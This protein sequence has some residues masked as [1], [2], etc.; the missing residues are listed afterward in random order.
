MVVANT[1]TCSWKW[2]DSNANAPSHRYGYKTAAEY[3]YTGEIIVHQQTHI[4]D[5]DAKTWETGLLSQ[6]G[7]NA[8]LSA[9]E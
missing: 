3:Q 6:K 5:H 4:A 2:T 9:T 7:C 8:A 1:I